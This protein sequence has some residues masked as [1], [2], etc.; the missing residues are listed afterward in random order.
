[1][2]TGVCVPFGDSLTQTIK[3]LLEKK[4]KAYQFLTFSQINNQ[5][6]LTLGLPL[7]NPKAHA[8]KA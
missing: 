7:R 2:S 1:M 6:L 3:K 8:C 5:E 4:L